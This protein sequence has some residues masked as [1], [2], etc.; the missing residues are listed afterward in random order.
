MEV[1]QHES[2]P[3]EYH[4]IHSRTVFGFWLFLLSDLIFFG[5][6][7]AVFAVLRSSTFGGPSIRDITHLPFT[8]FETLILLTSSLTAGFGGASA[9]R[10][11]KVGMIFWF[12]MTFI[13]GAIFLCLELGDMIVLSI[14][15]HSWEKS[16]FLSGYFTLIGTHA[17]H[18][19]FALLWTIL[20]LI[21]VFYEKNV[22]IHI[23]RLTCLRM[24]WQFVNII[25]FFI[26][27]FVY[28]IGV[29]G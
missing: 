20:L 8:M 12:L 4:G 18:V 25:W 5:A 17:L 14:K 28:L 10:K 19:I 9:H 11:N 24:F 29:K 21:Q 7:F 15:G 23:R 3:D 27:V 22:F 16:A 6:L 26:F 13:L 2:Y 1:L